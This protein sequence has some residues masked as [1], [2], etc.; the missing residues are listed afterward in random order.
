MSIYIFPYTLYIDIAYGVG[1]YAKRISLSLSSHSS[2]PTLFHI[3]YFLCVCVHVA[4][5]L[6]NTPFICVLRSRYIY[7]YCDTHEMFSK[8]VY[9]Y[10]ARDAVVHARLVYKNLLHTQNLL[11]PIRAHLVFL[12][13][14]SL[15]DVAFVRVWGW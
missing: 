7:I 15:A 13:I 4:R 10:K 9:K 12:R 6:S 5:I 3:I 1:M 14:F 2:P 8:V 11:Q